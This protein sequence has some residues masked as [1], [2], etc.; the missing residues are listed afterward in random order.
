MTNATCEHGHPCRCYEERLRQELRDA[1]D[2]ER[3]SSFE[4]IIKLERA[5]QGV[6]AFANAA[7]P[8]KLCCCRGCKCS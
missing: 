2:E 4:H 3:R 5:H 8:N 6:K 1:Y 7:D